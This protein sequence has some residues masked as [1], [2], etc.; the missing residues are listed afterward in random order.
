MAV[1][2]TKK[3]TKKAKMLDFLIYLLA[4]VWLVPLFF[5]VAATLK[6]HNSVIY[7]V[8][9]WFTPP[10][11]LENYAKVFEKAPIV[12]WMV[13]SFVVA[14]L[15]TIGVVILSSLA[16]FGLTIRKSR[17]SGVVYGLMLAGMMIPAEAMLVPL[18]TLCLEM[19]LLNNLASL[20]IPFLAAPLSV[21]LLMNALKSIP[22]E[23]FE[24]A[25]LDGC[26]SLR[27]LFVIAMPLIQSSLATVAILTFLGSWNSFMWPFLS[28]TNETSMTITVGLPY[29]KSSGMGDGFQLPMTASLISVIPTIIFFFIFQKSI[30]EGIGN[31]GGK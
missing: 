13:N 28:I 18:F 15:T 19:N 14:S 10:F 8:R 31:T 26:G 4:F 29:F 11:T 6:E 21:I 2:K 24:A 5:M 17:L 23:L 7:D 9:D 1:K 22:D 25:E 3:R 27:L 16:A 20:I 30:M 12:K